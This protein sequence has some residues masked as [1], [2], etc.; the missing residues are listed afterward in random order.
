MKVEML[1]G[2]PVCSPRPEAVIERRVARA[3]EAFF[4]KTEAQA[5]RDRASSVHVAV[6][7][8]ESGKLLVS[9]ALGLAIGEHL[10][11]TYSVD[12]RSAALVVSGVALAHAD[13]DGD[14][15]RDVVWRGPDRRIGAR[16]ARSGQTVTTPLR[17]PENEDCDGFVVGAP[18]LHGAFALVLAS[19]NCAGDEAIQERFLWNGKQLVSV[20]RLP[21]ADFEARY[22]AALARDRAVS[23]GGDFYLVRF[24]LERCAQRSSSGPECRSVHERAVRALTT[25]GVP[26]AEARAGVRSFLCQE[27]P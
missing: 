8:E 27:K 21:D 17:A 22:E 10:E 2:S 11:A 24:D 1:E 16:L 18:S 12:E 3:L 15:L 5:H 25:G 4:T 26:E 6:G 23:A 7:C 20:E 14:G 9:L 19:F 13:L